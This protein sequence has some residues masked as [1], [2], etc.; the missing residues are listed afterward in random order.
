DVDLLELLHFYE[1]KIAKWLTQ[2]D[3]VFID[4]L[5]LGATGKIQKN[6]LRDQ[7]KDYHLPTAQ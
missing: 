3:V 1:W 7:F 4:A 5:P 2:D 6:K